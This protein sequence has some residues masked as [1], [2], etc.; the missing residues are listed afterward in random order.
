MV[1]CKECEVVGSEGARHGAAF[2]VLSFGYGYVDDAELERW[3]RTA[4]GF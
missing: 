3:V 1:C 2:S 4:V